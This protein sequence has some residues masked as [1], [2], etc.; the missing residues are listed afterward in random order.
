MKVDFKR[1]EGEGRE[2]GMPWSAGAGIYESV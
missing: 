2:G 1:G